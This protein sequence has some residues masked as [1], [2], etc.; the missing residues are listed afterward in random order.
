LQEYL[1]GR[2]ARLVHQ[3]LTQQHSSTCT[4]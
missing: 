3:H 2:C 1:R 4:V